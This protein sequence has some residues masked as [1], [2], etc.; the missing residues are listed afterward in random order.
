MI[1]LSTLIQI[2]DQRM[3]GL[4]PLDRILVSETDGGH[5]GV[6]TASVNFAEGRAER[7]RMSVLDL[8]P[9]RV[10]RPEIRWNL[11][12]TLVRSLVKWR[13]SSDGHGLAQHSHSGIQRS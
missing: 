10:T 9:R 8:P 3:L 7:A 4:L 12:G 13:A 6:A 1:P 2:R 5:L 11:R